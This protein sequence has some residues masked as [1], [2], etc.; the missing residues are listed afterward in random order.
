M[1]VI[2]LAQ[3]LDILYAEMLLL[4]LLTEVRGSKRKMRETLI[5]LAYLK[6]T[7]RRSLEASK[8]FFSDL[9]VGLWLRDASLNP[10]F[11]SLGSRKAKLKHSPPSQLTNP[12]PRSSGE[13]IPLGSSW[14]LQSIVFTGQKDRTGG[15]EGM[16]KGWELRHLE[17]TLV[18]H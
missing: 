11:T 16:G 15:G 8:W 6:G 10:S 1:W 4:P 5:D 9:A 18:Y 2:Y 14:S 7:E 12:L 17:A 3:R 13:D